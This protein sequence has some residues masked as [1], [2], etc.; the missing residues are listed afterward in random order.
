MKLRMR[1]IGA[2]LAWLALS[3]FAAWA[4]GG[5]PLLSITPEAEPR[6]SLHGQSGAKYQLQ[7]TPSLVNSNWQVL[8]DFVL[9]T[10]PY[11]VTDP[12]AAA[13]GS[14]MYRALLL[15][16]PPADGYAP[17][18]LAAG[19]VLRLSFQFTGITA[20]GTLVL[21]S[22]TTGIAFLQ[23]QA[24]METF[25][26]ALVT[27][28]RL[29]PLLAQ[30]TVAR[31]PDT[32][33][34]M[35]Q[36]N[37]YTLAFS[38]PGQGFFQSVGF[39]GSINTVG[40][41]TRDQSLVGQKLAP[42]QLTAGES[43]T[44][45]TTNAGTTNLATLVVNSS[46]SGMLVS[47]GMAAPG[48]PGIAAVDI[49]Y[50]LLGPLAC[51]LKVV[52]PATG[53]AGVPQ[54]NLYSL[55]YGSAQAGALQVASGLAMTSLG[56]F[57][58]DTSLVGQQVALAQLAAGEVYNLV[59][60]NAGI[61]NLTTFVVNA[62]DSAIQISSGNMAPAGPSIVPVTLE[63][64]SLGPLACKLQVVV[65][66]SGGFGMPQTNVYFL[67]YSTVHSGSHQLNAFTAINGNG[68][69]ARDRSLVGQQL[70]LPQLGA[71]EVYGLTAVGAAMTNISTL[72]IETPAR[73]VLAASGFAGP[74]GGSIGTVALEY[75]RLGPLGCRVQAVI[76]PA[77]G[78]FQPQTNSYILVYASAD[79]GVF[80]S[81]SGPAMYSVGTFARDRSLLGQQVAPLQLSALESYR[82]ASQDVGFI[83]IE[84]LIVDT[85]TKGILF[86]GGISPDAGLFPDVALRYIPLGTMSAQI[87]AVIPP[88]PP[89]LNTR[90]NN[91]F[92][93]YTARDAGRYQRGAGTP[94]MGIGEFRRTPPR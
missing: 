36:T 57:V 26:A 67:V 19:E 15:E 25:Y 24:P 88:A 80:Q 18:A 21:N 38:G 10:S 66:D 13:A 48:M 43:Y 1:P 54:T 27:Y 75:Q 35:G 65:P 5:Q 33:T 71:G 61:T 87:E 81:V 74:A 51:Q 32:F 90:T 60:T 76:P 50:Q 11:T 91:Y 14:R 64:Q 47:S 20:T 78:V 45:A 23:G 62:P 72:A 77:D 42:L 16:G 82:F 6:I 89:M 46:T 55:V 31:P 69:F 83:T 59:T 86:A 79:G 12:A 84:S 40:E 58:R 7:Y 29:G 3:S 17:E 2:L 93:L 9:Q 4:G 34:P 41:F 70:A 73:G 56:T 49:E 39:A 68:S 53:G 44:F 63:Y 37:D 52:V 94:M 28:K 92:L 85:P 22:P 8:R 30:L